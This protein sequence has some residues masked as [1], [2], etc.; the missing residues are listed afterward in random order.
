MASPGSRYGSSICSTTARCCAAVG[1]VSTEWSRSTRTACRSTRRWTSSCLPVRRAPWPFP[2]PIA[3][4][5]GRHRPLTGDRCSSPPPGEARGPSCTG[6]P[7]EEPRKPRSSVRSPLPSAATAPSG[8][9]SRKSGGR[10]SA[11]TRSRRRTPVSGSREGVGAGPVRVSGRS[12]GLRNMA[13]KKAAGKA[14]KPTKKSAK[15]AAETVAR[16]AKKPAQKVAAVEKAVAKRGATPVAA[17]VAPEKERA[18]PVVGSTSGVPARD[19][20]GDADVGAGGRR[21]HHGHRHAGRRHR[22]HPAGRARAARPCWR[23]STSARRSC[24]STTSA[25]PSGSC[26]P[27]AP[28]P[29]ARSR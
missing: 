13:T 14:A 18:Q 9:P 26:T 1:M 24:T 4:S 10:L 11:D 5:T 7:S 16:S 29:T 6:S 20:G 12:R 27:A 28:A 17:R 15:A 22:Q 25:S 3:R 21:A 19:E 2:R 23:T 8:S